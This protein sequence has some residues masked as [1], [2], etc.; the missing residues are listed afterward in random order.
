MGDKKPNHIIKRQLATKRD[1]RI[2]NGLIV[3]G[4]VLTGIFAWWWFSPAHI[5]T[6]FAGILNVFD[7]ILFALVTYVVWH[8]IANELF[9]WY[10]CRHMT[11]VE[12]MK[13]KEGMKVAFL[14]AFV[15][16][17]EPYEVLEKRLKAM[18]GPDPP[19]ENLNLD[20]VMGSTSIGLC[21]RFGVFHF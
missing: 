8:Q 6:N 21:R 4:L 5:P 10:V 1:L 16:G 2:I 18:T 20:E 11:V 17:T 12:P 15:D 7:F 3:I 9:Y 13:S 14:T 19:H